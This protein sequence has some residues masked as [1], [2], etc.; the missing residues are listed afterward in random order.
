MSLAR[1]AVSLAACTGDLMS[2]QRCVSVGGGEEL[3]MVLALRSF[4]CGG[5]EDSDASALP[6]GQ[7]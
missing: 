4:G 1:G 7:G 3:R 5:V 6:G 2:G